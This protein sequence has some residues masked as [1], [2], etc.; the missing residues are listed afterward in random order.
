MTT[1]RFDLS[2]I[3]VEPDRPPPEKS[4]QGGGTV[5]FKMT[6][7]G[8]MRERSL[9]FRFEDAKNPEEGMRKAAE[10]LRQVAEYFVGLAEAAMK[11]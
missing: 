11:F 9:Q 5:I 3:T 6:A 1:E 10:Q 2:N 7:S 8:G 4:W